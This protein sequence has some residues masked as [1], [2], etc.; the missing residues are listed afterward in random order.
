MKILLLKVKLDGIEPV[1]WGTNDAK[2]R[3]EIREA[4]KKQI[5][6]FNEKYIESL[7]GA[8]TEISLIINCYLQ[9]P[10]TKDIDNLAKIPIDAIF[11]SAQ[12]EPGYKEW[13]GKITSLS[14]KKIKSSQNAL[15][16][17][18]YGMQY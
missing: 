7:L 1:T 6:D 18:I 17:T 9:N 5:P 2:K 4:I 14:I 10:F 15:E 3:S 16:A 13:E 12:N 11:Y 8:Y